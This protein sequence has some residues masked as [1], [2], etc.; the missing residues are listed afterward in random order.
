M[1]NNISQRKTIYLRLLGWIFEKLKP[2]NK[3]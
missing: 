1:A 3:S 2:I